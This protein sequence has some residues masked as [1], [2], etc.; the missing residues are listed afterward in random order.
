[1]ISAKEAKA[2]YDASGAESDAMLATLEPYIIAAAKEG[3]QHC[4]VLIGS[5]EAWKTIKVTPIQHQVCDKLNKLGFRVS[6]SKH[7]SGYVPRGLA[8]DDGNGPKYENYGYC[9]GW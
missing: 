2:L 5:E 6:I 9:I 3:K 7:G 4:F 8:D 1:M